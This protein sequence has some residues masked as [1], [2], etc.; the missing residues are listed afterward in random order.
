MVSYKRFKIGIKIIIILFGLLTIS[1]GILNVGILMRFNETGPGVSSASFNIRFYTFGYT[2]GLGEGWE[3]I[4]HPLYWLFVVLFFIGF[5]LSFSNIKKD[6]SNPIL[7]NIGYISG[8]ILLIGLIG[9]LIVGMG[10]WIHIPLSLTS[11]PLNYESHDFTIN[12]GF[13]MGII[14][15]IT[16]LMEHVIQFH[17]KIIKEVAEI[18]QEEPIRV[19]EREISGKVFCSSC[20]AELLDKT[21]PFCS[22]CGSPIK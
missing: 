11:G 22:K 19:H 12:N 3:F 21:R 8:I 5:L 4:I 2:V 16:I 15:G 6:I 7:K 13:I 14:L 20:G 18:V 9:Q 17:S 10:S 1:I